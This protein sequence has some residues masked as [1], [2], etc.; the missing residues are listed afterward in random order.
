MDAIFLYWSWSVFL[1]DIIVRQCGLDQH[2]L[3]VEW[4][5]AFIEVLEDASYF[6]I[7]KV[8]HLNSFAKMGWNLCISLMSV[9]I[10]IFFV[11]GDICFG[12][13]KI[14][15]I[16]W[17][18]FFVFFLFCDLHIWKYSLFSTRFFSWGFTFHKTAGKMLELFWF[19]YC[20]CHPNINSLADWLLYNFH[21]DLKNTSML[22]KCQVI[23]K[24]I[25]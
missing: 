11:V 18:N 13:L 1:R 20:H 17:N 7:F 5:K 2:V 22:K 3:H 19:P 9:K 21:H 8:T 25:F 24:F 23:K 6:I 10:S 4:G 15:I 12:M 14:T 16:L